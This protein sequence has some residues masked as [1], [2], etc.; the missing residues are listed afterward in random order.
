MIF[1]FSGKHFSVVR[2]KNCQNFS[3]KLKISRHFGL[4]VK[5]V[6]M[7]QFWGEKIMLFAIRHLE[8]NVWT[9]VWCHLAVVIDTKLLFQLPFIAARWPMYDHYLL[10]NSILMN[11]NTSKIWRFRMK[12]QALVEKYWKI[13][14]LR[15]NVDCWCT[16]PS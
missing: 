9:K 1:G 12:V 2:L 4:T 5:K 7:L 16:V 10:F 14:K 3:L 13:E 15:K 11:I 6:K 8:V